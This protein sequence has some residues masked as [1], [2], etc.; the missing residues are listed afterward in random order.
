M[1][2]DTQPAALDGAGQGLDE[3]R[4]QNPTEITRLMREL[5]ET[6]APVILNGPDGTSYATSLWSFDSTARRLSFC[7]DEQPVQ[8]QRLFDSDEVVAVAYLDSV[9]LQFDVQQLVMVRGGQANALQA[10]LPAVVYRFQRRSSYRVRTLDRHGPVARL[11]HPAIP[12]MTLQLRIIDVSIGGCAL[13]QPADVP[14]LQPG[15]RIEQVKV[16]LDIDARFTASLVIHHISS[17][18]SGQGHRLGCEWAEIDGKAQRTLQRFIDST[19]KRRH[20]LT[21]F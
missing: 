8:L 20:L 6:G 2:L 9:K 21:V 19:Q 12:D 15:T 13:L 4:V 16:E 17:Q 11:R 7:A 1:T 3:F 14:P 18:W 10:R 5:R